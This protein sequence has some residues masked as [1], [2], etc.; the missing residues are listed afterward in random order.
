ML[1]HN[2]KIFT[3]L[4]VIIIFFI[5]IRNGQIFDLGRVF[6]LIQ[7]NIPFNTFIAELDD[8]EELYKELLVENVELRD[9]KEENNKLRELLDFSK[10]KNYNIE[11]ANILGRDEVNKNILIIDIGKDKEIIEGQAVVINNGI[12][13]GKVIEVSLNSSKVSGILP[14]KPTTFP[15]RESDFT[16]EGSN[17]V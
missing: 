8:I 2:I 11:V 10:R 17:L 9:L 13:V 16:I 1:R 4:L 6:R 7:P 15:T 5:I 14:C 3:L 12:I